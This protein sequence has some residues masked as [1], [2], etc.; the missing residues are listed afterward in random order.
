VNPGVIFGGISGDLAAWAVAAVLLSA[1]GAFS[2]H[3]GAESVRADWEKERLQAVKKAAEV[4]FAQAEITTRVVTQY[5]DRV[6]AVRAPAEKIIQEI[7]VYV[8]TD[9]C[10]LPA[11]FRLLHDAA[12]RGEPPQAA[13]TADAAPVAAPDLA[14]TLVDNYTACRQNA[15][16]LSALQSW[17]EGVSSTDSSE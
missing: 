12:A 9:T 3:K 15:E 6:R 17:A 13:G 4:K 16:Q 8:P 14:R 2:W 5:V 1:A 10:N 7:P 11:G